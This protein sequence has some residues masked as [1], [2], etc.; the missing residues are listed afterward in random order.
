[1]TGKSTDI[2]PFY[3]IVV[4]FR[5]FSRGYPGGEVQGVTTI[6][7][8]SPRATKRTACFSLVFVS[9]EG[10]AGSIGAVQHIMVGCRPIF[11]YQ[12]TF[13]SADTGIG[14]AFLRT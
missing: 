13:H 1:M 5:Y 7:L 2:G 14:A 3:R 4:I 9:H 11:P 6:L 10:V 12:A 8:S